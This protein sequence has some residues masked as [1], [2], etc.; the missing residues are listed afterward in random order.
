M[1]AMTIQLLHISSVAL[2]LFSLACHGEGLL[3]SSESYEG[4]DEFE[5]LV[6]Q[7][8]SSIGCPPLLIDSKVSEVAVGHSRDML[9]RNYFAHTNPDGESP[10]DRLTSADIAYSRAAENIAAGQTSARQVLNDWLNS[11]GHRTNIENCAYT[12][13]GIGRVDNYWTHVFV[14]PR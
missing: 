3:D 6:N 12:H 2:L 1:P 9:N 7:H 8:R 14:T 11:S 4:V 5:I 10:F 13:H